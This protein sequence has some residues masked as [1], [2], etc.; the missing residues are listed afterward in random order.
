MNIPLNPPSKGDF[1][2]VTK[3][4]CIS[5]RKNSRFKVVLELGKVK[6]LK[7]FPNPVPP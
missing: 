7:N 4:E 3:G 5:K 1:D 6:I 2:M